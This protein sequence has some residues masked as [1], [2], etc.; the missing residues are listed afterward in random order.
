MPESNPTPQ[1]TLRSQ[2]DVIEAMIEQAENA[3]GRNGHDILKDIADPYDELWTAIKVRVVRLMEKNADKSEEEVTLLPVATWLDGFATAKR[4]F[5]ASP[6]ENYEDEPT[7]REP[8]HD[9]QQPRACK[10]EP[11]NLTSGHKCQAEARG[12]DGDTT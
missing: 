3:E 11:M 8:R 12:G 9:E 4:L 6:G 10:C 5:A 7:S 1:T 2:Y